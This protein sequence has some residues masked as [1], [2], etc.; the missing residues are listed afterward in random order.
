MRETISPKNELRN[1]KGSGGFQVGLL[2]EKPGKNVPTREEIRIDL[3]I[4]NLIS[5]ENYFADD[6]DWHTVNL[7][8]HAFFSHRLTEF[9][10][11]H[12][13]FR[14]LKKSILV[15]NPLRYMDVEEINWR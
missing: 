10:K 4:G 9:D 12:E 13:E 8:V 11:T 15:K 3:P 14:A 1:P 5:V 7:V 6:A 2:K